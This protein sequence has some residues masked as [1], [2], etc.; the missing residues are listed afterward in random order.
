MR[1][2][3]IVSFSFSFAIIMMQYVLNINSTPLLLIWIAVLAPLCILLK[4]DVRLAALLVLAGLFAGVAWNAFYYNLFFMPLEKLEGQTQTVRAIVVNYPKQLD[5]GISL[6]IKVLL[7]DSPNVRA[8]L[9]I[10]DSAEN[11]KFEPG[12]IIEVTAS[13]RRADYDP[14]I[15]S[16]LA[17]GEF[18][19]LRATDAAEVIGKDKFSFLYLPAKFS[20]TVSGK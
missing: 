5:Y 9:Y 7:D 11:Q 10:Y 18:L 13:F 19:I 15:T 8:T 4:N 2:L 6:P 17:K 1:K 20:H 3:A 16:L 12:E 14:E